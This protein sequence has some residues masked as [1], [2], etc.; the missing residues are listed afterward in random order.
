MSDM[1]QREDK[2]FLTAL[3]IGAVVGI[4][5]ALLFRA[6]DDLDREKI[7][8]RLKPLKKRASRALDHAEDRASRALGRAAKR[9]R[10]DAADR[11]EQASKRV[12][13]KMA[14]VQGA[15]RIVRKSSGK[16]AS[17]VGDDVAKIMAKASRDLEAS[18]RDSVKQA[19]R[20]MR[21]AAKRLA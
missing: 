9:V 13:R 2:D 8:K 5:A 16:I 10:H 11:Y 14:D 6:S 19:R 20:A 21:R 12:S 1:N 7:I 18:A 15:G 3:A 17:D 4:G